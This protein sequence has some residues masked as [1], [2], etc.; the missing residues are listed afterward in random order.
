MR[1]QV[2]LRSFCCPVVELDW[3]VEFAIDMI[4]I[5]VPDQE[6]RSKWIS[7]ERIPDKVE[8][9]P[10]YNMTTESRKSM[11]G[12]RISLVPILS[13]IMDAFVSGIGRFVRIGRKEIE[14]RNVF[15]LRDREAKDGIVIGEKGRHGLVGLEGRSFGHGEDAQQRFV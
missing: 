2:N 7:F 10:V 13:L 12:G 14:I 3:D 4:H 6:M 1:C 11:P 8:G 9:F 5:L 15:P